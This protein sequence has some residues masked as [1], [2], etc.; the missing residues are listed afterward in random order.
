MELVWTK[1]LS[2][3]NAIIDAEHKNLIGMV[4]DVMHG[5]KTRN[6]SI[7]PQAFRMLEHWLYAHFANEKKIAQ[8]VGFSFDRHHLAQQ[9]ALKELL[10]LRDEL[11]TKDGI[12]SDRAANHFIRSLENW[13]IDEHIIKLD[14]LMKP[15]LQNYAYDFL[16]D[17]EHDEAVHAAEEPQTRASGA[18]WC[19][20][21]CGCDD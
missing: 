1:E 9:H 5:I 14:M 6:C 15:V 18:R 4:N 2:V 7:L 21:G 11:V 20:C 16:P 10:H 13:V 3:G 17:C 19:G 8:A 12:W